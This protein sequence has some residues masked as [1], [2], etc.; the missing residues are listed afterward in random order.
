VG[1]RTR[2]KGNVG[3]GGGRRGTSLGGESLDKNNG[4]LRR[5]PGEGERNKQHLVKQRQ[6]RKIVEKEGRH[7]FP[8][9]KAGKEK[10]IKSRGVVRST[11][12]RGGKKGV[13]TALRGGG[14][15]MHMD[16]RIDREGSY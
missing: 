2:P 15:K 13:E 6:E 3:R 1:G 4:S 12:N 8:L 5:N 9:Q 16:S 11:R 14:R 10:Q 7:P